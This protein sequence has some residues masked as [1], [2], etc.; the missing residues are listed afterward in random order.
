MGVD[1]SAFGEVVN[2]LKELHRTGEVAAY[3]AD[4][5][6]GIPEVELVTFGKEPGWSERLEK[7]LGRAHANARWKHH[8]QNHSYYLFSQEIRPGSGIVRIDGGVSEGPGGTLACFLSSKDGRDFYFAAAGHVVSNFWNINKK[9][10]DDGI[11]PGAS[12]YSYRKGY[13]SSNSTRFLGKLSYLTRP[14]G[15][16][17]KASPGDAAKVDLDMGIVQFKGE[18]EWKQRT[19]CYGTFGEW[20]RNQPVNPSVDQRVMKCGAEEAHW[21]FAR[22]VDTNRDVWAYG[23]KR[24]YHLRGQVILQEELDPDCTNVPE[25]R[26]ANQASFTKKLQITSFAVPGDSG[27]MVVDRYSKQPLGMLIAGSVL[28]GLYV[29]T[30]ICDLW[31]YWSKRDLILLRA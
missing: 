21:T 4:I 18:F 2:E 3:S 1:E 14:P 27:A 7:L 28:D 29:M 17:H 8:R 15:E 31:K 10:E 6:E 9:D 22:V 5:T 23:P 25:A 16:F 13:P 30:P 12:I 24:V 20:P 19:T 26:E 11:D